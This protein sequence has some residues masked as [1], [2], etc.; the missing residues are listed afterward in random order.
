[1]GDKKD[2]S[3]LLK[4]EIAALE[5]RQAEEGR[6]LKEHLVVVYDM[7][8][9]I[10][11]V[12]NA[13]DEIASAVDS[14]KSLIN[15]LIGLVTGYFAQKMIIGS[16]PG[17]IKKLT[18]VLLNYGV[19]AA[20]SRYAESIKIFGLQLISQFFRQKSIEHGETVPENKEWV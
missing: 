6:L 3:A 9:P 4:E 13:F 18:G 20:I 5:I 12:K 16:K 14:R 7:L 10:N 2:A 8:K 19:A 17:L 15:S 11:L 1:M